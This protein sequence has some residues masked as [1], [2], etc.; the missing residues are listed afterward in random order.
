MKNLKKARKAK[1]WT[2]EELA[3]KIG[4]VTRTINNYE[5]GIYEPD[6]NTLKK[7]SAL[8]DCSIDYLLDNSEEISISETEYKNLHN[9]QECLNKAMEMINRKTQSQTQN[10]NLNGSNNN[11]FIGD[12][13]K[14]DK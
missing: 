14:M 8:L 12:K 10:I 3:K 6:V 13:N 2:A 1:G 9:A 5:Q 4:V 7:L 11:V